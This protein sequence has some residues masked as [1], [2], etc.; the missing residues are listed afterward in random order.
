MLHEESYEN[1]NPTMFNEPMHRE[2]ISYTDPETVAQESPLL[3]STS[4][5]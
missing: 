5:L 1:E 3:S 2:G 4:V